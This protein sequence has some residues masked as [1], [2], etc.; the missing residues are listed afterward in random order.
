MIPSGIIFLAANFI[1][2]FIFRMGNS[3]FKISSDY[4]TIYRYI[5]PFVF[6]V[7]WA[8]LIFFLIREGLIILFPIL[9]FIIILP[10]FIGRLFLIFKVNEVYINYD[11]KN[12]TVHYLKHEESF[13]FTDLKEI[14]EGALII[15]LKFSK[16]NIHFIRQG[17]SVL[18]MFDEGK[19][20]ISDLYAI[21][22]ANR[23]R[24]DSYE[25]NNY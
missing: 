7:F 9:G 21:I 25:K 15:T 23:L 18:P 19:F 8:V 10:I 17:N 24:D 16:K 11:D 3:G 1:T 13:L 2:E 14:R 6:M 20:A 12:F 22:D 4:T 5:C